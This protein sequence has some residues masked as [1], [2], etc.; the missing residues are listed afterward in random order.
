MPKIV[1]GT[2]K[3]ASDFKW[4][5]AISEYLTTFLVSIYSIMNIKKLLNL[6]N[7]SNLLNISNKLYYWINLYYKSEYAYIILIIALLSLITIYCAQSCP[8]FWL[9]VT[10]SFKE[11]SSEW[12]CVDF[13]LFYAR[14]K[15][16]CGVRY[17]SM[18]AG[19]LL[20]KF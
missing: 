14:G 18:C 3:K 1:C 10:F 2:E 16:S 5:C 12:I 9:L 8:R 20:F 6:D 13:Y 17:D 19:F 4:I 11:I 15:K 7:D